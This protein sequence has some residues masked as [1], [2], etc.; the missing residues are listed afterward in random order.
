[1]KKKL[2][3]ILILVFAGLQFAWHTERKTTIAAE[4]LRKWILLE[5]KL[6]KQNINGISKSS[7]LVLKKTNY[8]AA[9]K[10]YKHLEFFIEYYSPLAARLYING[11][12]VPKHEID[13]GKKMIP[14]QGFQR[15]EE[16]LYNEDGKGLTTETALLKEQIN[17]LEK[18]YTDV[19]ITDGDLLEMCQL[20][21]FRMAS[22]N[23]NG[24][25]AT[26]SQTNV[27][28]TLRALEGI[29]KTI[30]LFRPYTNQ[31][32]NLKNIFFQ[33][34]KEIANGKILLVKNKNYNSFNRLEFITQFINPV[35]RSIVNFHNHSGLSW[36]Q[37]KK[38]LQLQNGFLFGKES[39]NPQFFSMYYNDTL[40]L[41][42]Q[43]E[44]GKLLFNDPI[45]SGNNQ[46]SC[47][48][49]HNPSKAFTDGLAKSL[50]IDGS[51]H[52][53]RNAP[54]LLNVIYQKAFFYDGR[55]Y[56]LE[57]QAFDVIHNPIE[58]K[59]SLADVVNRLQQNEKYK[60]LFAKAFANTADEKITEYSVQKS[61]TEYEKTLVSFNSRF[62][63]YLHG[64]NNALNK[65]EINGYNIFA[66]KALCGS[67]HFTPLFN[68]TV[69]P[70][71][72]D[73]E[74][75]VIGTPETAANKKIDSDEGRFT[76]TE[77]GEQR[78][79]FKTPTVRNIELTAPYMHNGVYSNLEEVIEFYHRGGGNG[80]GFNIPNQT[81]PFDSLQLSAKEKED[82]I[83]F[84]KTLTDTSG[85]RK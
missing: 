13:L 71:F 41:N 24:Y 14:P 83:L 84:L 29:E 33:L 48:S 68:G 79:S 65:R 37:N 8:A 51:N 19:E 20:E 56:Q 42:E 62:D 82:I 46:Y 26:I 22:L 64:N 54:T 35:N 53:N 72:T 9:R 44:I 47:A 61:L 36:N 60:T 30:S 32:Q 18:Y 74:F 70:Y 63:Q 73:S 15:I 12:L 39:F 17:A 16:I 58:M 77:L 10:H 6:L 43:A 57:Q 21:L 49:C 25:D 27:T 40:Y 50:A 31:K 85:Y 76:V 59:S 28:E 80:F 67:C 66:G 3:V 38:A 23:L 78:Y 1:M 7:S 81:L 52:V 5:L 55:A 34:Q 11:P 45:L 4:P 2:T 69:P 75:E